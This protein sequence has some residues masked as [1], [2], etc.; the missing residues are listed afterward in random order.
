MDIAPNS[1]MHLLKGVPIDSAYEH[2]LWFDSPDEQYNTF[3]T[4]NPLTFNA[5]SYI[6]HGRGVI[7]V[8]SNPENL[9][10][11]NYMVF[12]NTSYGSKWFYCFV[13]D[14]EYIANNTAR[15]YFQVDVM[16]TWLFECELRACFVER[17]HS[18]TDSLADCLVDEG[19]PVG[20]YRLSS[21]VFTHDA[22]KRLHIAVAFAPSVIQQVIEFFGDAYYEAGLYGGVFQGVPMFFANTETSEDSDKIRAFLSALSI[23][24]ADGIQKIFAIP[25]WI[26]PNKEDEERDTDKHMRVQVDMSE[27]VQS[28]WV[29]RFGDPSFVPHNRKMY[30]YPYQCIIATNYCGDS[31][32]FK[33]ENFQVPTS[34]IFNKEGSVSIDPSI[35]MYPVNYND[36]TLAYSEAMTLSGFPVSSWYNNFIVDWIANEGMQQL[37]NFAQTGLELAIMSA[38]GMP[39]SSSTALSTFT[40]MPQPQE[41]LPV[42]DKVYNESVKLNELVDR[43]Q[44]IATSIGSHNAKIHRFGRADPNLM[45]GSEYKLDFGLYCAYI[46]A[47]EARRF[48]EYF[49]MFGYATKR[50]K[51]PNRNSRPR[52]NYV[53]TRGTNIVGDAP[54]SVIKSISKIYD[55]GI[56]FWKNAVDVGDYSL[57]NSPDI[58]G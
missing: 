44:E 50:V 29:R 13:N 58:G 7:D 26:I 25:R 31:K 16:Q 55:N 23:A 2:T 14:V 21:P 15:I 1:I 24:S 36:E 54:S 4:F 12:R 27:T 22:Q 49:D 42:F 3:M 37:S 18:A 40:N 9:L 45:C 32:Y 20:E 41:N 28:V 30:T 17:E 33:Y 19:I 11:Y 5:Q 8:K 56:T 57:D 39:M 52:W 46:R 38:T 48:D 34:P 43:G 47:E 51:V 35:M 53:K 10:N 6:R